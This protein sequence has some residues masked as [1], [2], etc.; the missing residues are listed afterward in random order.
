MYKITIYD[1]FFAM[2]FIRFRF[3][4]K[5]YEFLHKIMDNI[6]LLNKNMFKKSTKLSFYPEQLKITFEKL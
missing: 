5:A 6:P 2:K 1:K 3:F 4:T